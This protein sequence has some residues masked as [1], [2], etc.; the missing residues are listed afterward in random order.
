MTMFRGGPTNEIHQRSLACGQTLGNWINWYTNAYISTFVCSITGHLDTALKHFVIA[1]KGKSSTV[2][3]F[4]SLID[5]AL[6]KYFIPLYYI[7][8]ATLS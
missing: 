8:I 1:V 4:D 5:R 2:S 6:E 3:L 7:I